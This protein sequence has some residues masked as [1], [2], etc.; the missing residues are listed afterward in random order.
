L[1]VR[2][3]SVVDGNVEVLKGWFNSAG[4]PASERTTEAVAV[5]TPSKKK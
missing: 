2:R 4:K 1:D 5:A 3:R